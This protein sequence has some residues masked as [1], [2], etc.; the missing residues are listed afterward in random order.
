VTASP[1]IT[2]PLPP[3]EVVDAIG[4]MFR[5]APEVDDWLRAAFL[6]ENSDL[7][8]VE[9]SHLNSA[10][11]GILWTNVENTRQMRKVV[12]TVELPKP[13][14]AL[15]KW[16]K[17]RYE[18]QLEQW[19]GD[20]ELDFLITLDAPYC[21]G[22]SDLEFCSITEHELYHCAQKIEDGIPA[23]NRRTGLPKFA[24]K[25][26]DVEEHVGIV[27]RYGAGVAAGDTLAL[28]E[29]AKRAPE[30]GAVNVATM[31]GVCLR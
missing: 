3:I 28:V 4:P 14:P 19:F 9:H 7:Y 22:T 8:N 15:G 18:F 29:A 23:F 1:Q 31:C 26:H 11:L 21:A 12:G 17:A 5:P 10:I 24:I 13:H 25:G 6:G 2:R 16:A 27:R 30:I 20:I